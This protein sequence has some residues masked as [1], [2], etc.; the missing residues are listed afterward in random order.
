MKRWNEKIWLLMRPAA[1][2]RLP[3]AAVLTGLGR[4]EEALNCLML[5]KNTLP[6]E[7]IEDEIGMVKGLMEKN[8]GESS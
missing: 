4:L 3:S 8:G 2:R 6:L 7:R 1:M 5:A